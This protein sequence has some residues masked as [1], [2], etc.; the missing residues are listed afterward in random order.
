MSCYY[1]EAIKFQQSQIDKY[2]VL[3][4]KDP[5]FKYCL[6]SSRIALLA[7]QTIQTLELDKSVVSIIEDMK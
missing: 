2:T 4:S 1:R 7:L 5:K 3:S 6:K